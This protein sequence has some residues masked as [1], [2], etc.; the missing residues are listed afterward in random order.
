VFDLLDHGVGA[1]LLGLGLLGGFSA[2]RSDSTI[3]FK[4]ERWHYFDFTFWTVPVSRWTE[5]I[6]AYLRFCEDFK[7]E[8]GF[9]VSLISEAYLMNQD[10]HSLLSPTASEDAFTMDV[11]DTRMNDPRWA[12]FNSRFNPFIAGFGGRPLLNQTK[13]LDRAIVRQTLGSD[14]DRFLEI[15]ETEDPEGRFLSDYF[16]NLI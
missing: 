4:A 7:R 11:T 12:E 9:R 16:R 5:F 3:E 8:T 10:N 1:V 13:Q 15:R 6:P 14:W 2:R